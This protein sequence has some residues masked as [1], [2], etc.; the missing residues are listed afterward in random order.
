V[1][2]YIKGGGETQKFSVPIIFKMTVNPRT[3]QNCTRNFK[4]HDPYHPYHPYFNLNL[5]SSFGRGGKDGKDG[6]F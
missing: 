2:R 4:A 1:E 6:V 5:H 3:N